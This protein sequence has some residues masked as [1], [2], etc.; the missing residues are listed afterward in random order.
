MEINYY[1]PCPEYDRCCE[2]IDRYWE[3]GEYEACFKGHLELAEQGYPL[4]ECQVGWFYLKGQGVPQDDANA[5]YW[6]KRAAEHGDWD[7]QYNLG[8]FYEAG[9]APRAMQSRQ[10]AGISLL[11]GR[12]RM[13]HLKN[14][15]L[16]GF[17]GNRLTHRRDSARRLPYRPAASEALHRKRTATDAYRLPLRKG[18]RLFCRFRLFCRRETCGIFRF[19][20][21]Q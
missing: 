17:H 20:S 5:F 19:P 11:P 2:L 12:D 8:T 14:A 15:V 3:A 21:W 9:S 13:R 10:N 4:A 6:T 16:K 18:R 7:A 1:K